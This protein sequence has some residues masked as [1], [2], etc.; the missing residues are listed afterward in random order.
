MTSSSPVVEKWRA[1][2]GE[3]SVGSWQCCA[4]GRE[5]ERSGE[6]AVDSWQC[7]AGGREGER[8]GERSGELAVDSWQCCAGGREGGSRQRRVVSW[9]LSVVA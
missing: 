7:C 2:S 5:G 8:E 9:Q 3:L 6:L 4:G 1:D